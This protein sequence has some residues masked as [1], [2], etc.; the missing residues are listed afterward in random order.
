MSKQR[1]EKALREAQRRSLPN[2]ADGDRGTRDELGSVGSALSG[3][4]GLEALISPGSG[5]RQSLYLSSLLRGDYHPRCRELLGVPGEL[6]S[7]CGGYGLTHHHRIRR[8]KSE[9]G[10]A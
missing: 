1:R 10:V 7:R 2:Q 3:V 5:S 9:G 6:I 8:G 4:L